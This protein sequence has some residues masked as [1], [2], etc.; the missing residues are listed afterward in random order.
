MLSLTVLY[1][2]GEHF[3]GWA[4]LERLHWAEFVQGAS[5]ENVPLSLPIDS[6][7]LKM[8]GI[9]FDIAYKL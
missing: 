2:V 4:S 9:A 1:T 5:R 3:L 7:V 6:F 8:H